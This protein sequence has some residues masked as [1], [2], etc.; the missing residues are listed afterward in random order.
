MHLLQHVTILTLVMGPLQVSV[1]VSITVTNF[2]NMVAFP[3]HN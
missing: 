3:I 1:K 2:V